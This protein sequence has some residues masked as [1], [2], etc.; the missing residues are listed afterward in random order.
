[1]PRSCEICFY[2]LIDCDFIPK[3]F[4]ML[5]ESFG[6]GLIINREIEFLSE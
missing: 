1:M 6:E 4:P 3:Q 2:G 5:A